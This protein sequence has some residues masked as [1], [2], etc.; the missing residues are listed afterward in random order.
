MFNFL[1]TSAIRLFIFQC[2][3]R[4]NIVRFASLPI[5]QVQ[6]VFFAT[7]CFRRIWYYDIWCVLNVIA[8][9]QRNISTRRDC[10]TCMYNIV[11]AVNQLIVPARLYL[12]R[13]SATYKYSIFLIRY[14]ALD[15]C[16]SL[17]SITIY[18]LP[19]SKI[20]SVDVYRSV[21]L[22]SRHV[23]FSAAITEW[24]FTRLIYKLPLYYNVKAINHDAGGLSG[25]NY[26]IAKNKGHDIVK[27]IMNVG[28][29]KY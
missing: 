29:I 10:S 8:T 15:L 14:A 18:Y 1:R 26:Q 12:K 27:S 28:A 13:F 2:T 16:N 3:T 6:T 17:H 25:A 19:Q 4:V 22:R 21:G 7:I 9:L 24:E 20:N 11:I 23:L 5:L